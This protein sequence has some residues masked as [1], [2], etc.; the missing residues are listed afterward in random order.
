MRLSRR[1][2][3]GAA[4]GGGSLA[5]LGAVTPAWATPSGDGASSL[6]L[7]DPSVTAETRRALGKGAASLTVKGPE[8]L[9]E[10]ALWLA[11]KPG[12]RVMGLVADGDGILFQQMVP[13]GS[14]RWLSLTHHASPVAL[15]SFVVAG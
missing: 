5:A 3:I 9:A 11:A 10:A 6:L 15:M 8:T 1:A 2:L 13:R 4:L 14:A 7:V 12:R